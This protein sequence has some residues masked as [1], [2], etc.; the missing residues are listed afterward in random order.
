MSVCVLIYLD[1]PE[2]DRLADELVV[3]WQLFARGQLDEDLTQLT[4]I[5]AVKDITRDTDV[6]TRSTDVT[7]QLHRL[8]VLQHVVAH[9]GNQ[10]HNSGVAST[11]I[12]PSLVPN[13]FGMTRSG[14]TAQNRLVPRLAPTSM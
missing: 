5:T 1:F 4:T 8:S 10:S 14:V 12:Q 9:M 13:M 3:L 6:T 11:L 2:V 7:Q